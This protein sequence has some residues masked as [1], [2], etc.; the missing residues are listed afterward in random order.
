MANAAPAAPSPVVI[1]ACTHCAALCLHAANIELSGAAAATAA[2]VRLLLGCHTLAQATAGLIA[3]QVAKSAIVS[4]V[5][6]SLC[7]EVVRQCEE[8]AADQ[9]HLAAAIDACRACAKVCHEV[10]AARVSASSPP[11]PKA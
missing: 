4:G 8:A 10:A 2:R 5:C 6:A 9:P 1:D 3:L 11:F 7:E